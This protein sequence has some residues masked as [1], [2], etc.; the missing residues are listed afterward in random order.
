MEAALP[1]SPSARSGGHEDPVERGGGE[2]TARI[3]RVHGG[4]ARLGDRHD[5]RAHA[6]AGAGDDD[7]LG[8][9]LVGQDADL[10]AVE[11]PAVLGVARRSW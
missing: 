1:G 2:G 5:E 10:G 11:D 8:G 7:D 3:E 4:E 9:A 6:V